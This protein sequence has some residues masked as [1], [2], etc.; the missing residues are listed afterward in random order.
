MIEVKSLTKSY[1]NVNALDGITFSAQKGEILGFLGPNGAGKTTTMRIITCFMPASS[2]KAMVAGFD[3]MEEPME[4]KR[5]I[6][7]LP[8]S[9]PIYRELK[10]AE[11]LDFVG[12]VRDLKGALKVKKIAEVMEQTGISDVQAKLISTLSKGYRQRVGLAQALLSEPPVLILDEPTEGLDP[13]QI[14]EIREVIKNL[15]VGNRT[16]ILSSHILPEV[17][18][19]CDR[20]VIINKGKIVAED[21]PSNLASKNQGNLSIE[22]CLQGDIDELRNFLQSTRGLLAVRTVDPSHPTEHRFVVE[23]DKGIDIRRELSTAIVDKGFGLLEMKLKKL[24]LEDVFVNL[25]TK[26]KAEEEE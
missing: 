4:V 2:G 17:S 6:G 13:K 15:A 25:V 10:V 26:E 9:A 12:R 23:V 20:V 8:E 5:R 19:L 11:F 14:V 3:C 1:G 22:L 21:S 16:V 18:K 24:S 7:Y